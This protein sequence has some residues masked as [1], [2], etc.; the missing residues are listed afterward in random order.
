MRE[1]SPFFLLFHHI[2]ALNFINSYGIKCSIVA[3][4][5]R[6]SLSS[7]E[8]KEAIEFEDQWDWPSIT[9]NQA[10]LTHKIGEPTDA[11]FQRD[12]HHTENDT[13]EQQHIHMFAE[14]SPQA[15]RTQKVFFHKCSAIRYIVIKSS[16]C[17][18]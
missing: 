15:V 3:L 8:G 16:L 11:L 18:G 17:S 5:Q 1:Y 7:H 13:L 4:P 12:S 2:L 10:A 14:H 9:H 6:A